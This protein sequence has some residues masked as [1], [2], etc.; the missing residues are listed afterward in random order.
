MAKVFPFKA[1]RAQENKVHLVTTRSYISYSEVQ[2]KDKLENN[3]FSFM[4]VL[5]SAAQ[6]ANGSFKQKYKA[7]REH[8]QLFK[9]EHLLKEQTASFYLYEQSSAAGFFTGLVSLIDLEEYKDNRIKKHEQ[10][11]EKRREMFKNY[12]DQTAIHAEPVLLTHKPLVDLERF[13]D[14]L[15]TQLPLY[16]FYTHNQVLHRAWRVDAPESIQK[17]QTL[18]KNTQSFYIADGHHRLA[19][20]LDLYTAKSDHKYRYCLSFLLSEKQLVNRGFHRVLEWSSKVDLIEILKNIYTLI[21]QN[22]I[23]NDAPQ[24]Q[25][26]YKQKYYTLIPPKNNTQLPVSY[27]SEM[28]FYKALKI[29]DLRNTKAISYVS[30]QKQIEALFL[31]AQFTHALFYMP[32]VRFKDVMDLS[33][34]HKTLPPKST[35]ILPKLRSSL[36]IYE[37]E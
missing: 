15:K 1:L 4:H 23:I 6:K 12:L 33:D 19:S 10:T 8:F 9:K 34:E 26:Y 36:F 11:I 21:P 25:L 27:L 31:D 32:V 28:F 3:P 2:L 35:Y 29:K 24:V 7:V 17:I 22:K 14:Q 20:S 5:A 37:Y 16:D 13:Y 30:D 18:F